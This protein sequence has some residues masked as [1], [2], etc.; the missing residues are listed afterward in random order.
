[1][2][3]RG[4]AR[5]ASLV[6][7]AIV[8][9]AT[10]IRADAKQWTVDIQDFFF[11]PGQLTVAQGDTVTWTNL[12]SVDHTTTSDSGVWD[13]GHIPHNG[14]FTRQFQDLG[15]FPYHCTIHTSM[16]GT[17][18]VNPVKTSPDTWGRVK[19]LYEDR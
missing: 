3:T 8:L 16:I 13:S 15:T 4:L 9:L 19:K 1:M 6:A 2:R 12:G 18:V 17:I 14:T 10:V 5:A 11:D 7:G